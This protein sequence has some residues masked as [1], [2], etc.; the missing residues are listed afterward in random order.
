MGQTVA[1]GKEN[2]NTGNESN[3][4]KA[5]LSSTTATEQQTSSKQQQAETAVTAVADQQCASASSVSNEMNLSMS[6]SATASHET[7]STG[8]QPSNPVS[9]TTNAPPT[10]TFGK[11]LEGKFASGF[12]SAPLPSKPSSTSPW[13]SAFT[14]SKPSMS[15]STSH[16]PSS[17]RSSSTCLSTITQTTSSVTSMASRSIGSTAETVASEGTASNTSHDD[18]LGTGSTA[19]KPTTKTPSLTFGKGLAGKFASG[20]SNAPLPIKSSSGS[21][22]ASA[23]AG[24]KNGMFASTASAPSISSTCGEETAGTASSS[25]SLSA[26]THS[27]S[28]LASFTY[29]VSAASVVSTNVNQSSSLTT[30]TTNSNP[31]ISISDWITPTTQN[32]KLGFGLQAPVGTTVKSD[33]DSARRGE[34]IL[35]LFQ[36]PPSS[37]AP[38]ATQQKTTSTSSSSS[39]TTTTVSSET[40]VP[41]EETIVHRGRAKLYRLKSET[42]EWAEGGVGPY[43]ISSTVDNSTKRTQSSIILHQESHSGGPGIRLI[44]HLPIWS[45]MTVEA[46]EESSKLAR[47]SGTDVSGVR[48]SKGG[49]FLLKFPG[50]NERTKFMDIVKKQIE[51]AKSSAQ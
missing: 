31:S 33:D 18:V 17:G 35:Q 19:G 46:V 12:S 29:P 50:E 21:P 22:W 32:K 45:D 51:K 1:K 24:S 36:Q 14:D 27:T 7:E 10:L 9:A 41:S 44:L 3:V 30:T 37:T 15:S 4:K 2:V 47:V 5:K 38:D 13:A 6:N 48:S 34:K 25:M 16:A 49:L 42:R 8:T 23:F 11:G 28:G 20:F 39:V 40:D 26:N 43:R